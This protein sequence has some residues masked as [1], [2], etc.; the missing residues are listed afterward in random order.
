MKTKHTRP[1]IVMAI[2]S[3]LALSGCMSDPNN[4]NKRLEIAPP[5]GASSAN[6]QKQHHSSIES[7]APLYTHDAQAWSK[8]RGMIMP[9]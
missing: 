3:V 5:D 7:F 2:A 4:L 8:F 1:I 9:Q 6:T